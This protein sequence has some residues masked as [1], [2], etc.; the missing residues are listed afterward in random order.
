MTI[1][2]PSDDNNALQRSLGRKIQH[3]TR[4][5]STLLRSHLNI[6]AAV[7]TGW[8][9]HLV[10]CEALPF[11]WALNRFLCGAYRDSIALP[12]VVL[13][14]MRP[15]EFSVN[16]LRSL[17]VDKIGI[18]FGHRLYV[19]PLQKNCCPNFPCEHTLE[20]NVMQAVSF[21]V[22]EW[23]HYRVRQSTTMTLVHR[24]A[25][26]ARVEP[27]EAWRE[28]QIGEECLIADRAEK[29]SSFSHTQMKLLGVDIDFG[30]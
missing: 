19:A 25:M 30:S 11:S 9:L 18:Y 3:T 17:L 24:L 14:S 12:Q 1:T 7:S 4:Y 26:I 16:L 10:S 2:T 5:T 28:H 8:I 6:W 20:E 29:V 15:E 22:V 13:P 27:N 23:T 21:L